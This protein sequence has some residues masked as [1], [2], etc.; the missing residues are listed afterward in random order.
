MSDTQAQ[1]ITFIAR[2]EWGQWV[3]NV[4]ET[5]KVSKNNGVGALETAPTSTHVVLFLRLIDYIF[6]SQIIWFGIYPR[7]LVVL[8]NSLQTCCTCCKY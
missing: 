4:Q 8:T 6:L 3:D 7:P 5:V 2:K 1:A